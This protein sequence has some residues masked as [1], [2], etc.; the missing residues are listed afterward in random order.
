[1]RRGMQAYDVCLLY[2]D[3]RVIGVQRLF[4]DNDAA[5]ADA[6]RVAAESAPVVEIW[7]RNRLVAC[8]AGPSRAG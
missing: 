1:M 7:R 8:L 4:A 6:G 2:P 5:A 3:G